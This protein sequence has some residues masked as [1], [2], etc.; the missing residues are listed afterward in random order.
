[1][2]ALTDATRT[3][4]W[5]RTAEEDRGQRVRDAR[6][7]VLEELREDPRYQ[8]AKARLEKLGEAKLRNEKDARAWTEQV[9]RAL[10]SL[11]GD[12]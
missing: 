2:L 4:H 12:D 5:E 3:R 10:E 7:E 6:K 9:V 1:M 8:E 11:P